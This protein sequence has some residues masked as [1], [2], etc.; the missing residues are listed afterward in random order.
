MYLN[1]DTIHCRVDGHMVDLNWDRERMSI[2][3]SFRSTGSRSLVNAQFNSLPEHG[4]EIAPS[5]I[6]M[7][8]LLF[9]NGTLFLDDQSQFDIRI[10]RILSIGKYRSVHTGSSPTKGK[11]RRQRKT[12]K[13]HTTAS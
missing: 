12:R 7:Y 9:F 10:R 4:L 5:Y 1:T 8:F 3:E 13:Q 2:E 6:W 11:W